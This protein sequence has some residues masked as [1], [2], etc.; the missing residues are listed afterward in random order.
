MLPHLLSFWY[1]ILFL[2]NAL[3]KNSI[4]SQNVSLCFLLAHRTKVKVKFNFKMGHF[5]GHSS[6]VIIEILDPETINPVKDFSFIFKSN[7]GLPL[8][9]VKFLKLQLYLLPSQSIAFLYEGT[10]WDIHNNCSIFSHALNCQS[11]G[12]EIMAVISSILNSLMIPLLTIFPFLESIKVNLLQEVYV[13]N[14]LCVTLRRWNGNIFRAKNIN[15]STSL[16]S[17]L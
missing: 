7:N 17:S 9:S 1:P 3:V 4:K 13:L 16:S 12:T 14:N 5:K 6:M 8:S 15:S 10:T 11:V 2:A